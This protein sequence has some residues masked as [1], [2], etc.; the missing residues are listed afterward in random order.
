M[1][2]GKRICQALRELR[3]RIADANNIPFEME[4]CTHEGD[5]PGTCPKCESEVRYLMDSIVQLELKGTPV[6]ID[7]IMSE[8][9]LC[10][11]FSITSAEQDLSEKP[12]DMETMGQPEPPEPMTLMGDTE[13][14]LAG[15][16]VPFSSYGFA[17]VIAK[18]IRHKVTHKI[19]RSFANRILEIWFL[20]FIHFSLG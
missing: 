7:G 9:E 3:K 12:E 20:K 8:D 10:K 15:V 19:K 2:K 14:P 18:E 1:E 5:C 16:P 17:S 13:P 4:E 11:A 6:V